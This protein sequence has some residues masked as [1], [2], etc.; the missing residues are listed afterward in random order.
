MLNVASMSAFKAVPIVPGYGAAKAGVVQLTLNLAAAWA[1]QGIRVNAVAPGLIESN[2]TRAMKGVEAL[3]KPELARTLMRRWGTPGR[4]R[5]DLPVPGE[6]GG[7]LRHRSDLVRR[8]R[9]LGRLS[10]ESMHPALALAAQR[11]RHAP[12]DA[13]APRSR[14]TTSS[15]SPRATRTPTWW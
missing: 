13:R 14:S 4:C 8:R 12:G 11:L 1:E 7:A 6:R 3:E 15:I 2:M 5:T 10:E 9:L